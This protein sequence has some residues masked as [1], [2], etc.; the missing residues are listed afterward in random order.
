MIMPVA[1]EFPKKRMSPTKINKKVSVGNLSNQK[2]S[3]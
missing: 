2:T 1:V 3:R